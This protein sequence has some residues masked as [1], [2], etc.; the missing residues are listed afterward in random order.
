[1]SF[2][3]AHGHTNAAFSSTVEETMNH[4]YVHLWLP[5]PQDRC[6]RNCHTVAVL[7]NVNLLVVQV[8]NIYQVFGRMWQM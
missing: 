3:Y 4:C 5:L 8:Y 1:M 6:S 2:H 7:V